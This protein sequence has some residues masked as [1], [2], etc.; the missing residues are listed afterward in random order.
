MTHATV[1]TQ[2][3]FGHSEPELARLRSQADFYSDITR[4]ALGLVGIVPGMRVLDAGCGAGDVSLLL[5]QKVGPAGEVIAVDF[6]EDAVRSCAE[7]MSGAGF[8][9]VHVL[10]E[11]VSTLSLDAPVDA[12]FW[13]AFAYAPSRSRAGIAK[14]GQAGR[15]RRRCGFPGVRY[16]RGRLV[17]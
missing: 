1:D 7:R 5:A 11:D 16:R 14:P 3:V 6:A 2:Y 9:T 15:A 10:R 13:P 4:S 17:S 8:D 12:V